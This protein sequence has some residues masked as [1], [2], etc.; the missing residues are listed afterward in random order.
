VYG[1]ALSV[2]VRSAFLGALFALA[3]CHAPPPAPEHDAAASPTVAPCS[4]VEQ[5]ALRVTV[6]RVDVRK[7]SLRLFLDDEQGH[8]FGAFADIDRALA[9]RGEHLAFATNAGMFRPDF[10]AVG[11]VVAEGKE[12]HPLNTANETGHFFLK[13]NGVFLVSD[14]GARVVETSEYPNLHEHVLLATQSGSLLVHA[15]NIHPAFKPDS[16]SRLIRNDVGVPSPDVALF[17]IAE[18]PLNFYE[19]ATFFRDT[20]HC[21]DALF[22]DG[23]VSSLH[24]TEL[25]RSDHA[26]KVGPI[27]GVVVGP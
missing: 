22:L 2:R 25:R 20:L 21:S 18:T 24:S 13:P 4:L 23:N 3:S 6:C 1:G 10:S 15:G 16:D 17:A 12:L 26:V 11:L 9:P 27:V 7:T 19:F 5:A 14:A 8:T